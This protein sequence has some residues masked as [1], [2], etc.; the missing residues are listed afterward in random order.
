M[1]LSTGSFAVI[2]T[3]FIHRVSFH[4]STRNER[5]F[6]FYVDLELSSDGRTLLGIPRMCPYVKRTDFLGVPEPVSDNVTSGCGCS[7]SYNSVTFQFTY[8]LMAYFDS[9]L[10]GF[11]EPSAGYA[12][13]FVTY[14]GGPI[15]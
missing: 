13:R 6:S 12:S 8:N 9:M 15:D 2:K 11:S 14:G 7:T 5:I 1:A 10:G 4:Q 3:F